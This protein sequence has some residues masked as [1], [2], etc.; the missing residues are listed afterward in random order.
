M[1]VV[2]C[3]I[4]YLSQRS[5]S[6]ARAQGEQGGGSRV[7]ASARRPTSRARMER[8][9]AG[10]DARLDRLEAERGRLAVC[11]Q[12]LERHLEQLADVGARLGHVDERQAALGR[13]AAAG[14]VRLKDV[15]EDLRGRAQ[16]QAVDARVLVVARDDGDVAQRVIVRFVAGGAS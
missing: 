12:R 5:R 15:K 9:M 16:A 4:A 1:T 14:A 8:E 6:L 10:R 2:A 7:D 13:V 3:G 11:R